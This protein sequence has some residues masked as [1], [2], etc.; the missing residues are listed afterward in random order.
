MRT[1]AY[2]STPPL[3]AASIPFD[4][5]AAL[6]SSRRVLT[7]A[8]IMFNLGRWPNRN[9]AESFSSSTTKASLPILRRLGLVGV[10]RHCE[11]HSQHAQQ[12]QL[13]TQ[14]NTRTALLEKEEGTVS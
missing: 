14:S 7:K 6:V 1:T 10:G 13:K 9:F 3:T 11:Q 2:S 4:L 12:Q 8:S 5:P